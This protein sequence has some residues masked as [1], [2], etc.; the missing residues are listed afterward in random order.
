MKSR[1]IKFFKKELVFLLLLLIVVFISFGI[2]YANFIYN[3]DNKRAVEMFASSLSYNM[4]INDIYTSNI[5]V[6]KGSSIIDLEIEST[7]EVSSYYKLLTNSNVTVYAIEG[8]VS[9]T[10]SSGEKTNIKLYIVNTSEEDKNVSF[11]VSMGYITNTLDDVIIKDGYHMVQNIKNEITYDN[12]KWVITKINEDTSIDL[13]SKD[14]FNAK[15]SGYN[16]YNNLNDLLNSK[17]TTGNSKSLTVGDVKGINILTEGEYTSVNRLAYYPSSLMDDENV[18]ISDGT[19]YNGYGYTN[20]MLVRNKS[21]LV[22]VNDELLNQ[23]KYLLNTPYYEVKNGEIFYYVIEMDNGK[24][25]LRK[26]YDSNNTNYE[27]SS[28]VR[29]KVTIK[30]VAF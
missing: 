19:M 26:L 12:K 11:V 2:T 8:F 29:C 3:S 4:K 30:D 6:A 18:V 15:I 20:K 24:V 1:Y 23:N 9:G 16:A 14:V 27:I 10:I 28:S 5:N 22:N 21:L 25:N 17:C 7:N 13:I